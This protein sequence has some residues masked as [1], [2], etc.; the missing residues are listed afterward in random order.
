MYNMCIYGTYSCNFISG[1]TNYVTSTVTIFVQCFGSAIQPS[2]VESWC[3]VDSYGE[4][5][6]CTLVCTRPISRVPTNA[7]GDSYHHTTCTCVSCLIWYHHGALNRTIY[8]CLAV[9]LLLIIHLWNIV[10]IIKY[11]NLWYFGVT[12]ICLSHYCCQVIAFS[13]RN[14]FAGASISDRF[15]F[16][17]LKMTKFIM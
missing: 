11:I 1:L 2:L 4:A 14:R 17:W 6:P 16:K 7:T 15:A 12:M 3:V 13:V 10:A 8:E 9:F 5:Q